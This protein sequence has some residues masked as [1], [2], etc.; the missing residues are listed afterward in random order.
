MAK[1]KGYNYYCLRPLS[2]RA[3]LRKHV[4]AGCVEC[5][6]MIGAASLW[7]CISAFASTAAKLELKKTRRKS[8]YCSKWC[9]TQ[10][11][12]ADNVEHCAE[13]SRKWSAEKTL[14]RPRFTRSAVQ[15]SW[16]IL[17]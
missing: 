8:Q 5:A 14:T 7:S 16:L 15:R 2:E 13:Y 3:Y 1:D 12:R 10:G 6:T 4:G 11:W 9:G 17:P